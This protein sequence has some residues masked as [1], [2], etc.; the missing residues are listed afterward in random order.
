MANLQCACSASYPSTD[1][2]ED[3]LAEIRSQEHYHASQLEKCRSHGKID[4]ANE[5]C[6]TT[7]APTFD[8]DP[9]SRIC[10][11]DD[12]TR[13]EPFST[14]YKLWRHYAQHIRIEEVCVFCFKIFRLASEF[15]RHTEDNHKEETGR[16]ATFMQAT[17]EE[18]RGRINDELNAAKTV[19]QP[20]KTSE[21]SRKRNWDATIT[22]TDAPTDNHT[23]PA[24]RSVISR[25]HQDLT[26][27]LPSSRVLAHVPPASNV[28]NDA[29]S[30]H[31]GG[32]HQPQLTYAAP[33]QDTGPRDQYNARL[34][35]LISSVPYT[36]DFN[37]TTDTWSWG[38]QS[39]FH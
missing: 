5:A 19:R 3:H 13:V 26:A 22:G 25:S 35:E 10:P 17:L 34:L 12:C 20:F 27:V 14:K 33:V 32:F 29:T 16:R 4:D 24:G 1:L 11:L 39:A 8:P 38:H 15:I 9:T 18:L 31:R 28:L 7:N 6:D 23:L 30:I 36:D 2:L 21:S 37:W